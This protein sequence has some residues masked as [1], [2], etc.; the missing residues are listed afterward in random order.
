MKNYIRTVHDE[1]RDNGD[2]IS[3]LLET[4]S[5]NEIVESYILLFNNGMYYI[6]KTIA[7]CYEYMLYRINT[8]NVGFMSEEDFDYLYDRGVKGEFKDQVEW[9]KDDNLLA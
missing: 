4:N 2:T 1:Y 6:F 9:W 7:E 8:I 3:V 5:E